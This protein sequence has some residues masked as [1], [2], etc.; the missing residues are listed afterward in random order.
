MTTAKSQG[1]R[2]PAAMRFPII[3][4]EWPRNHREHLRISLDRYG[5][6]FTLDVRT[7]WKSNDGGFRPARNGLTLAVRYLPKLIDSLV[8]AARRADALCLIELPP[9]QKRNNET[10]T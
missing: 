10:R 2:K 1:G 8:E 3:V 9:A 6:A 7:W 4:C 5:S